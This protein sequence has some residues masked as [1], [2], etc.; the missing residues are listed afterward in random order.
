MK[1][2]V[3]FL[4]LFIG[5]FGQSLEARVTKD[6][7]YYTQDEV[8]LLA[9]RDQNEQ[10]NR[11]LMALT[12][13]KRSLINGNLEMAKFYL[14]KIK[15]EDTELA[16]IKLRYQ[17]IIT[18]LQGKHQE[19]LDYINNR[20]FTR[21]EWYQEICMLKVINLIALA[22]DEE[23]QKE[24]VTCQA[25][26][27]DYS[28]N[29]QLWSKT[30]TDTKNKAKENDILRGNAIE[31]LRHIMDEPELTNIWLK[32]ALYLNREK[33][34]VKH[35]P[36]LPPEAYRS[37]RIRELI[38]L[39]LF[40]AGQRDKAMEFIEDLD[41]PN[42]ENIRGNIRL[43]KN[44]Y[45]LAFGHYKLA[46][47]KKQNSVNAL[48]RALPLAWLLGQWDE[49]KK[50]LVRTIGVGSDERKRLA[51]AT[52]FDIRQEKFKQARENLNQLD[53]LFNGKNPFEVEQLNAY[54]S[55][56]ESKRDQAI[57]F[58]AITCKKFDG[59][60]CYLYFIQTLWEDLGK[61]V[62]REENLPQVEID[63]AA[64]KRPNTITPLNEP[65]IVDQRDI[66]ELDSE[67]IQLPL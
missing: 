57:E 7:A 64:L 15:T 8:D 47:Q 23:M 59:S 33:S 46:L 49:G 51:L 25:A 11:V 9:M 18:F 12:L 10:R 35:I 29:G 19:S 2:I 21:F 43:E 41:S 22:R 20:K 60:G 4:T 61:T 37:K 3:L 17:A 34:V 28:K 67:M 16:V 1:T 45:E 31:N 24:A 39:V 48:E 27:A 63:I 38:G 32:L 26:T 50:L 40:R 6:W 14:E 58:S 52:A 53:T 54:V 30:L 62:M 13:A 42:A 36:E 56:R 44:E 65:V 5:C 55:L 66:E